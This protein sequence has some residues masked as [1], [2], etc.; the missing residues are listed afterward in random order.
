MARS[1]RPCVLCVLLRPATLVAVAHGGPALAVLAGPTLRNSASPIES[2]LVQLACFIQRVVPPA[3][4]RRFSV[5]GGRRVAQSRRH[6]PVTCK[7]FFRR[8]CVD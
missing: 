1:S 8:P 3:I 4:R 6:D 5:T 2:G 7:K